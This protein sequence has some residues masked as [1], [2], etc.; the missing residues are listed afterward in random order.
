MLRGSK[1]APNLLL[2]RAVEVIVSPDMATC[3]GGSSQPQ[4]SQP[5]TD[6]VHGPQIAGER[7]NAKTALFAWWIPASAIEP[8]FAPFSIRLK[9]MPPGF[10]VLETEQLRPISSAMEEF[11]RAQ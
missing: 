9:R 8:R 4:D 10:V 7:F 5:C 2:S 6:S 3:G 1:I 11:G